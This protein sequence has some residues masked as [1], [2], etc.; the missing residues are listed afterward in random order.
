ML[1]FV[2][3]LGDQVCILHLQ[4]VSAQT[5][6]TFQMLPGHMWPVVHGLDSA[7]LSTAASCSYKEAMPLA[8]NKNKSLEAI[9]LCLKATASTVGTF[10][11]ISSLTLLPVPIIATEVIYTH[12]AQMGLFAFGSEY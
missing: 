7:G 4:L 12:K 8:E 2:L 3:N 6:A 5:R 10:P 1:C 9:I 11:F